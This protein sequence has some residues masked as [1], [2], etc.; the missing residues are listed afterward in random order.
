MSRVQSRCSRCLRTVPI[1]P[2]TLTLIHSNTRLQSQEHGHVRRGQSRSADQC[3]TRDLP[4]KA[5]RS[6][7]VSTTYVRTQQH[8]RPGT[9]SHPT[10]STLDCLRRERA[11]EPPVMFPVSKNR[12]LAPALSSTTARHSFT[13]P[14]RPAVRSASQPAS[15]N[16]SDGI[17][18]L[19]VCST[20]KIVSFTPAGPTAR[21]TARDDTKST[22]WKSPTERTLAVGMIIGSLVEK[23]RS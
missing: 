13:L 12:E 2:F 3:E 14:A 4:S 8:L 23:I 16:T 19:F 9:A 22:E 1:H 5:P 7:S 10:R 11:H 20:S 21:S 17:E 18:T 6:A 15:A